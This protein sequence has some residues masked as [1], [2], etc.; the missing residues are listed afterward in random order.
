MSASAIKLPPASMARQASGVTASSSTSA[1]ATA[2]KCCALCDIETGDD[3]ETP[4]VNK[5]ETHEL[6]PVG[7]RERDGS[8]RV[9]RIHVC[10]LCRRAVNAWFPE[11]LL[12][13]ELCTT[14]A[15]RDALLDAGWF[16]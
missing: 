9:E 15:L 3:D 10:H 16:K 12:A 4:L 2:A 6:I 11:K 7:Q 14:K 13:K 8:D 1:Q 5:G